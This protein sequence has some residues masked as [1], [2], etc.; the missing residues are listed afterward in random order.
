[1]AFSSTPRLLALLAL[2]ATLVVPATLQA[3]TLDLRGRVVDMESGEGVADVILRAAGTRAEALSDADGR[4]LLRGLPSGERLLVLEHL[5]YGSHQQVVE[6]GT[7][8]L[9]LEIRIS[10]EAIAIEPMVVEVM[11]P[12]QR[13]RL[14]RGSSQHVVDEEMIQRAIGT[15]RHLGDLLRQTVPGIRVRQ[16]NNLSGTDVCLEFRSA[17]SISLLDR[18]CQHPAVYLDGVP[19]SNPNFLYGM[20]ALNTIEQLEVIPPGEAGARYGTG[21]LYGVILISTQTPGLERPAG[22][23]DLAPMVPLRSPSESHFDW[24]QDPEG[25]HTRRAFL[26][27]ALGNAAGVAAGALVAGQCVGIDAKEEIVTECGTG[28]TALA[29]TTAVLI[30]TVTAALSARWSGGTERSVGRFGPAALGAAVA[31]IPGYAFALSTQGAGE[32]D[33]ANALGYG[34]L[35]AVVPTIV[36]GADRLFRRL[37]GGEAID[38]R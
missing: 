15:S 36:T 17:Q 1:M 10:R 24:S 4:F 26:G 37:R 3:Q 38:P 5:A 30:P 11:T 27:T 21:S 18:G 20:L 31:L 25:H 35:F 34:L 29:V 12:E 32:A 28:A 8:G 16:A 7:D 14:A 19:I 9:E 22:A 23:D 6:V 2:L 33:V 13:R